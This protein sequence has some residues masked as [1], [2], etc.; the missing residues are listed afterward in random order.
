MATKTDKT[1]LILMS[2]TA[3]RNTGIQEK[4]GLG[5]RMVLSTLYYLLPPHRDN[6]E[7]GLY[8]SNTIVMDNEKIEWVM[9]RP[10]T[11][12]DA[13]H[14]SKYEI[15]QSP[16]QSPVFESGKTSRINVS[17]FM[18]KLLLDEKLWK[19]WRYKMPVLYNS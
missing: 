10:D 15:H 16:K 13:E 19:E 6:V 8:L 2:T 11:L 17:A 12:I 1:K 3:Y 18:I 4:Y 14:E 5:D 9:V 7:A